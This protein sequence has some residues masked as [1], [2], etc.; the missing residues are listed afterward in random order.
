MRSRPAGRARR[1]IATVAT[2]F[3]CLGTTSS[4]PGPADRSAA[5]SATLACRRRRRR[6]RSA[7][8]PVRR[9]VPPRRIPGAA[10]RAPADPARSPSDRASRPRRSL[11]AEPGSVEGV[12]EEVGHG[13]RRRA[14]RGADPGDERRWVQRDDAGPGCDAPVGHEDAFRTVA[15]G[16]MSG[17]KRPAELVGRR[18]RPPSSLPSS[19]PATS[20]TATNPGS[21]SSAMQPALS[22]AVVITGSAP[23]RPPTRRARVVGP[24]G[25][26]ADERDHDTARLRRRTRRRDRGSCRRA[27]ARRRAPPRRRRGTARSRR[28]SPIARAR[29]RPPTRGRARTAGGAPSPAR[30]RH[31][32]GEHGRLMLGPPA[33]EHRVLAL[34]AAPRRRSA[35]RGR[36][37]T[38]TRLPS[39]SLRGGG[40]VER[41]VRGDDACRRDAGGRARRRARR[42]RRRRRTRGRDRAA[43]RAPPG[44]AVDHLERRRRA[45]RVASMRRMSSAS[46]LDGDDAQIRARC[47]AL[48]GDTPA[49]RAH[50]PQHAAVGQVELAERERRAPPPS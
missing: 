30:F 3:A 38:W 13:V 26:A 37:T 1:A 17:G 28:P 8:A 50:V 29:W 9:A 46:S 48:H 32:D 20:P 34:A 45:R 23:R 14:R 40:T 18:G 47:R 24:A 35:S 15:A 5:A 31:R 33:D 36:P 4:A 16:N 25:V 22:V 41:R 42:S 12:I 27:A 11:P 39:R 2:A 10:A 49:A 43:R 21:A 44:L 6:P 7:S 19:R